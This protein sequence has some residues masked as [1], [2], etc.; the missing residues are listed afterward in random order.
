MTYTD[1]R[2]TPAWYTP[3]WSVQN[4]SYPENPSYNDSG[5]SNLPDE[6]KFKKI[7]GTFFNSDSMPQTGYLSF[8]PSADLTYYDSVEEHYV[9]LTG[10][11]QKVYLNK[12]QLKINLL[13]T[14]NTGVSPSSFVYHVKE[15]WM[16][17]REYDI[18][19]PRDGDESIDIGFVIQSGT[20]TEDVE[21]VPLIIKF[22]S[23]DSYTFFSEG[24]KGLTLT[25]WTGDLI[26]RS[27]GDTIMTKTADE[28]DN[29][30][31]INLS[32]AE[33][34]ELEAGNVTGY[35]FRV[36][37]PDASQVET[38]ASGPVQVLRPY[39]G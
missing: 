21:D 30:F 9:R 26:L 7:V 17:G 6:L 4:P 14:D 33:T 13:A 19:V 11:Y 34:A 38:V 27:Y 2:L 36:T 16:G 31:T 20:V 23:G 18:V 5:A 15:G 39:G 1:D 35:I 10:S 37:S 25:G 3:G 12:G 32:P 22:Y 8:T 28:V 24:A 29:T